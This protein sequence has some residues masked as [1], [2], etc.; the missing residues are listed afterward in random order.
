MSPWENETCFTFLSWLNNNILTIG[1]LPWKELTFPRNP[2]NV[3]IHYEWYIKHLPHV[4]QACKLAK[5]YTY[6]W[7][8]SV[9]VV[10]RVSPNLSSLMMVGHIG[11]GGPTLLSCRHS[12]CLS[13]CQCWPFQDLD[14]TSYSSPHP[15]ILCLRVCLLLKSFK[16][17][18][19]AH[20]AGSDCHDR[21][22]TWSRGPEFPLNF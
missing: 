15:K 10:L 13:S 12:S 5:S 11:H 9:M 18:I 14:L 17:I 21:H 1:G 4:A 7:E 8:S 19:S 22:E 20:Q 2:S 6:I 16:P 3:V